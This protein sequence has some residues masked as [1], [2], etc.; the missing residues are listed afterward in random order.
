MG[1]AAGSALA[2]GLPLLA[3]VLAGRPQAAVFAA[4][5]AFTGLYGADRPYRLR[6]RT[7]AGVAVGF[8]AAVA[9]GSAGGMVLEHWW[10]VS[11]VAVVAA[12]ATWSC[13][14]AGIGSP[15]AW[16]FLFAFAASTQVPAQPGEVVTRSLLAGGGAAVAWSVAMLGVLFDPRGPERRATA[17]ALAATAQVLRLGEGA[18]SRHWHVAHAALRRAERYAAA[19]PSAVAQPLRGRLVRA[20]VLLTDAV[21][22]PAAPAIAAQADRLHAEGRALSG[23]VAGGGAARPGRPRAVRRQAVERAGGPARDA[24]SPG[25]AAAER[26][27]AAPGAGAAAPARPFPGRPAAG[28]L[29]TGAAGRCCGR[30][31]GGAARAGPPVLG[32]GVGR[33]SVAGDARADDLAPQHPAR[34]GARRQGSSS[35]RSCC[36]RT[37]NPG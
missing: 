12:A 20:E 18:S 2:M 28:Q 6:A 32:A 34:A 17:A 31:G 23:N 35:V 10:W 15:G 7:L 30:R 4:F 9:L 5:G 19:A 22:A 14:A 37:R 33:C 13:D 27:R 25:D 21:L 26:R 29:R 36:R 16:M 3:L 11:A 8:V 24:G 1:A